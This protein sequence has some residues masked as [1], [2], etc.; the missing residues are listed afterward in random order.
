MGTEITR[1]SEQD[2]AWSPPRTKGKRKSVSRPAASEFSAKDAPVH[3]TETQRTEKDPLTQ[4]L[5]WFSVVLGVAEVL[6]PQAVARVIGVDENEHTS[7]LRTYGLREL[8]AGVGILSRPKPTYWMWNRVL[9]DAMDL[10]TLGRA[11]R[12]SRTDKGRL[13]AAAVAVLGVT[14]LDLVCSLRLTSEA[15][16]AAGHDE[17]SFMLQETTN[18]AFPVAAV[19]TVNKPIE[20][21]YD[22]WKDPE[23]F[24]RFM[25]VIE[26]VRATGPGRSH[27]TIKGPADLNI[28]WDAEVSTDTPSEAISWRSVNGDVE[29]TGTVRFRRAAGNRGT[30]VE[31]EV[32]FKPKGGEVGERIAKFL[33]A[34]PR[35]QLMNDLRRFKQIM[36]LG[37]IVRSDASVVKGMH[38]ARPSKYSELGG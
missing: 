7:L 9:G 18:G 19:I 10:A 22:F 31:L 1:E 16:P 27:W 8:A 35:T 14:A 34:I 12:S 26:T 32:Q 20:E 11:M 23:N 38:P 25:D 33:L 37:E 24:S 4:S 6:A 30:E 36:E 3:Y 13:T 17:G 28:E 29:N 15:S 2:G 21:V 5:G